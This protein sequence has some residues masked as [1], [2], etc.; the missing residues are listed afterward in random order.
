MVGCLGTLYTYVRKV[1][2][3]KPVAQLSIA[4]IEISDD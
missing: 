4:V 1:I 2:R 3:M